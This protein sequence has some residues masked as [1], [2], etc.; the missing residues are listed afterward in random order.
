MLLIQLLVKMGLIQLLVKVGGGEGVSG[1]PGPCHG[2]VVE[3]NFVGR[4]QQTT[5]DLQLGQKL[6]QEERVVQPLKI[7]V[8]QI[9]FSLL[10]GFQI[11]EAG[12]ENVVSLGM[13]TGC[14][15]TVSIVIIPQLSHREPHGLLKVAIRRGRVAMVIGESGFVGRS[16]T[17]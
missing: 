1:V 4:C 8:K 2:M 12:G 15:A 9:S 5:T 16:R 10:S 17:P 7:V 14:N 3:F 13:E 11:R 6:L